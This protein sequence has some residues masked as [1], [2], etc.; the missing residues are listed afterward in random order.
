MGMTLWT[1]VCSHVLS[2]IYSGCNLGVVGLSPRRYHRAYGEFPSCLI[3]GRLKLLGLSHTNC[4]K[5]SIKTWGKR[6]KSWRQHHDSDR[7]AEVFIISFVSTV[8]LS[9]RLVADIVSW[10]LHVLTVT[11]LDA[12]QCAAYLTCLD[13][14][15]C[16]AYRMSTDVKYSIDQ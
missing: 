3:G 2:P 7:C 8:L 9:L 14:C 15:R 16:A 12:C 1:L 4:V 5:T 11:C 13:A 6:N 10:L